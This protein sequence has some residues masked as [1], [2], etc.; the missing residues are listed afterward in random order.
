VLLISVPVGIRERLNL[1]VPEMHRKQLKMERC[2]LLMEIKS[3]AKDKHKQDLLKTY[4]LSN[5][6]HQNFHFPNKKM[7]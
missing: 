6:I 2:S 3:K 4:K 5:S 7:P 1:V